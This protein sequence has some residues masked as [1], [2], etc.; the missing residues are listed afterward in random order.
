MIFI[1]RNRPANLSPMRYSLLALVVVFAASTA[2]ADTSESYETKNG[3]TYG[4]CGVFTYVDMFTD[5][6][7]HTLACG[8]STLTDQTQIGLRYEAGKT[9]V[10]LSKGL[11][12][13]TADRIPIAIRIDKGQ[14]IQRNAQWDSENARRAYILDE[15][16]ARVLLHDLAHGERV[17][18]QVG[19]E[20]GH[21]VLDGSGKA[22]ADFRQRIGLHA[23]QTLTIEQRSQR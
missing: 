15:Q 3:Q 10:L 6:T 4:N 22:V 21:I 2:Q 9:I 20:R 16:L 11:Q 8:Q 14:L 1:R 7:A 12:F 5:D 17:A 18:V 23:Q 13:H 19:N